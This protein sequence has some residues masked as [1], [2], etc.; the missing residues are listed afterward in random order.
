M[1]E[2]RPGLLTFRVEIHQDCQVNIA[3]WP[4]LTCYLRAKQV[5]QANL[6][7]IKKELFNLRGQ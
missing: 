1:G 3:H 2:A 5:H 6:G 4:N 7:E